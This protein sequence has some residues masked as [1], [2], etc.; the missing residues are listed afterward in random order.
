MLL[1]TT[2][3]GKLH[4][5]SDDLFLFSAGLI[6]FEELHRWVL[7]ADA[8]NDAVGWLQSVSIAETAIPLV[9]PR[10]FVTNYRVRASQDSLE[11]LQVCG[12]DRMFVLNVVSRNVNGLTLNLKAPLLFNLDRRLGTQIVTTDNQPLQ[13][14]LQS[15]ILKLHRS[16]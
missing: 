4:V 16:A 14:D 2:R 9:S 11:S 10:R 7:L 8:Q 5:Q 3:F 6:G 1:Y 15:P 13:W 12:S